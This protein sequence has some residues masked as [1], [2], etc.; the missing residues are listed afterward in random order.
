M[1]ITAS[2]LSMFVVW[3]ASPLLFADLHSTLQAIF[4]IILGILASHQSEGVPIAAA[5][6]TEPWGEKF[7]QVTDPNGVVIQLVQWITPTENQ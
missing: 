6:E 4:V 7:F 1:Q 3:N 5:I 2:A